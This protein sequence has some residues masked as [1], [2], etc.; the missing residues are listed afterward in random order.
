VLEVKATDLPG[1]VPAGGVGAVSLNV[2][3]TN[4]AAS[5]FVSVYPCGS[6]P[7]IASVNNGAGATVSNGVLAPVSATGTLCFYSLVPTDIIVD[8]SGWFAA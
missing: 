6:R 7:L 3:V 2:A 4:A 8:V 1:L 5:G